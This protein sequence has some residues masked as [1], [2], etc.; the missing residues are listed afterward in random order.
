MPADALS[1]TVVF[2]LFDPRGAEGLC[3]RLRPRWHT[4]FYECE[5]VVLVA[6]E[7]R[8]RQDDLAILLRAVKLWLLDNR[9]GALRFH[10][11]G[12]AFVLESDPALL[13]AS[14]A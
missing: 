9:V 1:E 2:E 6:T 11:D 3:E 14:I 7:L 5:D 12:R 4:D 13:R 8:P 10:L